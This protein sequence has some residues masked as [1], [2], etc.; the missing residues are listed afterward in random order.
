M[1][2]IILIIGIMVSTIGFAQNEISGFYS[3]SGFDGNVD[4]NIFLY[5]NGSYFLELSENVTDDIVES[6]ALSYGKF[7]LTNNEVTLIDKIHNYK[8]RLVLE[9]KTLKITEHYE[10]D[11]SYCV[12]NSVEWHCCL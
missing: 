3:L 10:K 6:L 7:S 11:N 12:S 1:K 8:M 5:K 2:N 4:C 9:N